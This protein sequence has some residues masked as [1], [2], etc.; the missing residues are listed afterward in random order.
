MKLILLLGICAFIFSA[1]AEENK[2]TIA[3]LKY[4]ANVAEAD[5]GENPNGKLEYIESLFSDPNELPNVKARAS[6]NLEIYEHEGESVLEIAAQSCN[7]P[8]IKFLVSKGADVNDAPPMNPVLFTGQ[9]TYF[10]EASQKA[11]LFLIS[12]GAKVDQADSDG[13]N[14]I[15]LFPG[16][17]EIVKKA[18][19][20]GAKINQMNRW[21][22]FPIDYVVSYGDK[23]SLDLLLSKG[24]K[25]WNS[26]LVRA[27]ASSN[28]STLPTLLDRC[29]RNRKQCANEISKDGTPLLQLA[30]STSFY[31]PNPSKGHVPPIAAARYLIENGA[32]TSIVAADGSSAVTTLLEKL[33]YYADKSPV[34]MEEVFELLKVLLKNPPNLAAKKNFFGDSALFLAIQSYPVKFVNLLLDAGADP[35]EKLDFNESLVSFAE[36]TDKPEA[37]EAL[38]KKMAEIKER[39]KP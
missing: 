2:N 11:A 20:G 39:T 37:A 1:R 31:D 4:L 24:A 36:R 25:L 21:G 12:K 23:R 22:A 16:N 32:D 18:I 34:V 38:K 17:Y 29:G 3:L 28:L 33:D 26:H 6:Y 8:I 15:Q 30:L 27:S 19:D 7:L 13:N 5:I 35:F 10:P 9:C 14:L